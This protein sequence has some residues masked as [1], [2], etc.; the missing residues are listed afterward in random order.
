MSEQE[1]EK[2]LLDVLEGAQRRDYKGYSKFD[3]LHGPL[4]TALSFGLWPLRL[5]WTQ[6]VM[7]SPVD[8]RPLLLVR[9]DVNPESPALFARSNL[10]ALAL[11]MAGPFE[12]R[13]RGCLD[14]LLAHDASA[15]GNYHGR[16]WGYHHPWQ[17]TGFYQPP[18]SP[19]CYVTVI[20]AQALLHGHRV[21]GEGRYLDAALNACEFILK[22]LTILHETD[23]EKSLSYVPNMRTGFTVIN[24]NALCA[25][26]L[27]QAGA[28]AGRAE[29][30]RE[31][32][33]LMMFVAGRQTG[34]GAWYYTTNP[35]DSLVAHD[36]YHTGMILDAM[37]TYA[38]AAGDQAFEAQRA[39]GLAFYRERLFTREGAPR[40]SSDSTYP[41]DAHGSGQGALTFSLAGD[42]ETARRILSWAVR[43]FYRGGG[44]FAYQKGRFWDKNFTLLHWCNGWMAR[45]LSAFLVATK[46]DRSRE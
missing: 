21:L 35:R 24:V 37:T 4:T 10:D 43:H 34:Y 45:G 36:N 6:A 38:S 42:P 23:L 20:A 22:D 8:L 33:K 25:S 5:I 26:L 27:A 9:K 17:S 46:K 40:W 32:R 13:A 18:G 31:A 14:W 3:G 12:Q 41:H 29:L 1:V 7:R 28:A 44:D 2:I 11:G 16:C 15:T 39:R 30:L 19:N